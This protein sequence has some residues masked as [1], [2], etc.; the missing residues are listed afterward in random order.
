[1]LESPSVFETTFQTY[2]SDV[3]AAGVVYFPHFFR[4]VV[5]AE[6]ELFRA[7]GYGRRPLI[8]GLH[9]WMPR[10]EAFAKFSKPN[11]HGAAIRVRLKPKIQGEKA[12]RYDFEIFDDATDEALASGYITIVCVDANFKATPVPPAIRTIIQNVQSE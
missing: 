6:E 2:W 5:Q 3:D 1:M 12:I 7:A 10:V 11:G 9:V 4:F 8:E